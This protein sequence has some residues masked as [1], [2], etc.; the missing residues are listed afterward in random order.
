M[1]VKIKYDCLNFSG[2]VPCQYHKQ[3][4]VACP[5]KYYL[6]RGKRILIIK[7]AAIGDVIRTTPL[8]RRLKKIY[9]N[10]E[11]TWVTLM[12]EILP[13]IV[14]IPLPLNISSLLRLLVDRFDMLFN[15]DKDKA[16]CALAKLVKAKIKKGFTLKNGKCFPIDKDA[17]HNF[18][19]GLDDGFNKNNKFSYPAE[20]FRIVG[21]KFEGENYVLDKELFKFSF[22]ELSG[23]VMGLNT[24]C[25]KRWKTRLWSTQKWI[26]L[27]RGLKNK[28]YNV[29]LLGGEIEH[30]SNLE[31]ARQSQA[32]YLGHFSLDNFIGLI[33]KCDLIVTQVT[34]A[35]HIAIGLRKKIILLN[36]IFNEFEF[37]LYGLGKIIQPKLNCLGCLKSE[38]LKNCMEMIAPG[39]VISEIENLLPLR[40]QNAK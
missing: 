39:E 4:S 21:L 38:C 11:I 2:E 35:L 37:E 12:P 10:S 28:G 22:P 26:D 17:M 20:I 7:L 36:N 29:I 31:I 19:T 32:L 30:Q 5:C 33:D 24:G 14:D 40:T 27:A 25:G 15:L 34:L 23:P 6:K 13:S 8:L 16:A 1:S 3:F 18:L 9:Q